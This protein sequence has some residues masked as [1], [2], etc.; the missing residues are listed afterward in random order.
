MKYH[1]ILVIATIEFDL[2][3][4]NNNY[5]GTF[6]EQKHITNIDD[7]LQ[8]VGRAYRQHRKQLREQNN[9]IQPESPSKP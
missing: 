5:V 9:G 4:D 2:F 3:D 6:Q 7:A 8:T 1:S